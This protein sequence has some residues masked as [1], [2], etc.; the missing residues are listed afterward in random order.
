MRRERLSTS[1]ITDLVEVWDAE[2]EVMDTSEGKPRSRSRRN[3]PY[4]N[5][6][7]LSEWMVQVPERLEQEWL[8]IVCPVG[9]RCTVVCSQGQTRCYARNGFE[10]MSKFASLLPGGNG[11][12]RGTSSHNAILDCIFCDKEQTFYILDVILWNGV[13]FYGCDTDFRMFWLDSHQEDLLPATATS[14]RNKFI[15]KQLTR[16]SCSTDVIR[17][18]LTTSHFTAEVRPCLLHPA[19][20]L[21]YAPSRHVAAG[22]WLPI[23]A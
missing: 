22:R 23:H 2:D 9:K 20:V 14:A 6:L 3:R 21:T 15:F 16:H 11:H 18:T 1:D 5:M 10:F 4:R 19:P 7:M 17:R 8:L 12:A 13:S